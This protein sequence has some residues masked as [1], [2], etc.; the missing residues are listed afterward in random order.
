MA[1]PV[2]G[3]ARFVDLSGYAFTGKHAVIDLMREL[4]GFHVEHFA[5]EFCMLRVQGGILDLEHALVEDWSPIRSDAALRRFVK[6]VRRVGT[7]NKWSDP[8][9]WFSAI[10]TGYDRHYNGRFFDLSDR[11]ISDLVQATWTSDWPYALIEMGDIELFWRKFTSKVRLPPA[12]RVTMYLARPSD[13]LG[14]TRRYLEDLLSSNIRPDV[15]TIVMHNA[16]EPFDPRRSMKFFDSARSI[17]VDRDPRDNY[18]QM[19]SYAPLAM[20]VREFIARYRVQREATRHQPDEDILRIRFEDLVLEYDR[21]VGRIL[22]HLG[23][24][25][26]EHTLKRQHFDPAAS[27]RNVGISRGYERPEEISTIARELPQYCDDRI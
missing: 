18:V 1:Q 22:A 17:V 27:L 3:P 11:Y 6:L 9:T 12:N 16:F 23:V 20:P 2:R 7:S 4:R 10:G 21:T 25:E 15:R 8:R 24:D 26:C 5:F 13:F 19:L 14:A